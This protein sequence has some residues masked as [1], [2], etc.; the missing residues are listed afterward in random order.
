LDY[1][2]RDHAHPVAD[3]KLLK[4]ASLRKFTAKFATNPAL[5]GI[6]VMFPTACNNSNR[7]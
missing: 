5:N 3:I 6:L 7:F 2:P 4:E 1:S